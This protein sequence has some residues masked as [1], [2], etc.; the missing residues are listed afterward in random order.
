MNVHEITEQGGRSHAIQLVAKALTIAGWT[1]RNPEAV[2]HHID[3]LVAIGIAPPKQIPTLYR[4]ARALLTTEPVIEAVGAS[5]SGEA[6]F[7]LFNTDG[8]LYVAVGS[9]HTDRALETHDV[10]LSKQVCA[11][12]LSGDCWRF[13]EVEDH[14]DQLILRSFATT[15]GI[16]RLY[17]EGSVAELLHP[18]ELLSR[19]GVPFDHG[20]VLFGGTV[21]VKGTMTGA[22]FF[23]VELHDPVLGRTLACE[24]QIKVL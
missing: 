10:A 1:G 14:W 23:R 21:P 13:D 2:Q 17:Q 7:C 15:D 16:E 11:K 4:V 6:E 3:E 8:Q 5:S 9:D 22:G 20:N 19:I 24:Y 12:P 18:R